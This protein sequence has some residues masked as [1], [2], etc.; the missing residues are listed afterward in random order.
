MNVDALLK[1]DPLNRPI[2][3]PA[4]QQQADK[5]N[6]NPN[7]AADNDLEARLAMLRNAS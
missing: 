2:A 1:Q 3:A 5:E 6:T 4:Q 7:A